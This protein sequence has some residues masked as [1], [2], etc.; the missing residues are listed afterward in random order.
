MDAECLQKTKI[1]CRETRSFEN[2]CALS[3]CGVSFCVLA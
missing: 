1:N 3:L 2:A